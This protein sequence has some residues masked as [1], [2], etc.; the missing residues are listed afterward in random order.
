MKTYT[1]RRSQKS[2]AKML[3]VY[4]L[5]MAVL[6]AIDQALKF[7][8]LTKL[9]DTDL[10]VLGDFIHLYYMSNTGAAFSLLEGRMP[11]LITVTLIMIA[12]C[13]FLL[14]RHKI[15]GKAGN[16]ALVL[17]SAG[18]MGNLI[19]RIFRGYVVDYIYPKFIHFAVFNFADSCVVVGAILLCVYLLIVEKNAD[20]RVKI[21]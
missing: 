6:V 16:I 2:E 20:S 12:V 4:F 11:L 18:G 9:K 13:I 15:S 14:V 10:P 19:D 1:F 7:L 17:I 5:L 8:V 3:I 21:K